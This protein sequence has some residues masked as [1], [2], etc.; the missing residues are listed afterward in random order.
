[1]KSMEIT[2]IL[3]IIGKSRITEI[4]SSTSYYF[5]Y[6]F[7]KLLCVLLEQ[8]NSGKYTLCLWYIPS[9]WQRRQEKY[10]LWHLI[11]KRKALA[12]VSLQNSSS[13]NSFSM[14]LIFVIFINIP[15]KISCFF[16]YKI[17]SKI[18]WNHVVYYFPGKQL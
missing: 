9:V 2:L 7:L 11:F 5:W 18:N 1:M 17:L 10:P 15:F 8:F 16:L 12:W 3:S 6:L 13:T 4:E 14:D